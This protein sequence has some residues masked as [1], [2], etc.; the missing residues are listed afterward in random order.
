MTQTIHST[1]IIAA[2][3]KIGADVKIGPYCVIG[4]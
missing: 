3:A 1:A 2:K 4:D